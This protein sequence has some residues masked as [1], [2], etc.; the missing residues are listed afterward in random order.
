MLQGS[1]LTRDGVAYLLGKHVRRAAE[2]LPQLRA[3]RITPY[4][5]R[6]SRA[7]ALLQAGVE[8][9][10]YLGHAPVATTSRYIAT[11]L[12][13]KRAGL[14]AFW[15]RAGLA[16]GPNRRRRPSTKLLAFLGQGGLSGMLTPIGLAA[17]EKLRAGAR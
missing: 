6:H 9:C 2:T 12:E 10:N 16:P 17:R 11:N 4:T 5:M 1:S 8:V 14:E 3:R 13:M 15:Q 7:V